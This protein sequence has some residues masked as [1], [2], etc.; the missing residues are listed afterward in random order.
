VQT[1]LLHPIPIDKYGHLVLATSGAATFVQMQR[2]AQSVRRK[3]NIPT[4][5]GCWCIRMRS[6]NHNR[7]GGGCRARKRRIQHAEKIDKLTPH[8]ARYRTTDFRS[9]PAKTRLKLRGIPHM[10]TKLMKNTYARRKTTG[11][12]I[13]TTSSGSE[14][15]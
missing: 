3:L 8:V 2:H 10:G 9:L 15:P 1:E 14:T 11:R 5:H 6:F 7:L 12:K 13:L 4:V